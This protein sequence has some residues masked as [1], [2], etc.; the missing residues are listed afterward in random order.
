MD[1]ELR[2]AFTTAAA[3]GAAWLTIWAPILAYLH[4]R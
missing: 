4:T 1:G 2:R 3:T